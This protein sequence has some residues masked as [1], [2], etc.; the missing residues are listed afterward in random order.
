MSK[1]GRNKKNAQQNRLDDLTR[2]QKIKN[3]L[4]QNN[5]KLFWLIVGLA[6]IIRL[7]YLFQLYRHNPTVNSFIH[8]SAYF[9]HLAQQVVSDGMIL[10]RSFYLS[11][12]YIYFLAL[13]YSIGIHNLLV[14]RLLQTVLGALGCGL[15]FLIGKRFFLPAVALGGALIQIFYGPIL[16]FEGNLLA[17]SLVLFL[18][19]LS[20]YLIMLYHQDHKKWAGI[21]SGFTLA[22]A[23]IG[24]PNL[25]LVLPVP[26]IYLILNQSAPISFGRRL[27]PI[28]NWAIGFIIPFILTTT[29][30]YLADKSYIPLT[31]HGG[32]NFY[33]GNHEQASGQWEAPEGME[34]SVSAINL[35]QAQQVAEKETGKELTPV[36]VSNF[37]YQKAWHFIV[38]KPGAWLGLMLKKTFLFWSGYEIPLNFD[39]YFHQQFS[40][41]LKIPFTQ[42]YLLFPLALLG[43]IYGLRDWKKFWP[44]YGLILLYAFSVILFFI[45]GRYRLIIIPFILLFSAYGIYWLYER[46]QKKNYKPLIYVTATLIILMALNTVFVLSKTK[47]SNFGNDYYNIALAKLY[48]ED[49]QQAV[50]WGQ[51]AAKAAPENPN[52]HYNL[53]IAYLKQKEYE[54]AIAAFKKTVALNPEDASALRNLGGLL[55]M[56]GQVQESIPILEQAIQLDATAVNAYLN[57]GK[58]YFDRQQY[59]RAKQQWEKVLSIDP[60]NSTAQSNIRV[61]KRLLNE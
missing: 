9:N 45:S 39:Y 8:D 23:V 5:Q 11:P 26:L 59:H 30:N 25:L 13:F 10:D 53:G 27:R 54:Q 47:Q 34:S 44:L 15:T 19:L 46:F 32:I 17:T 55:L 49:Y 22:L 52:I 38:T 21:L 28:L 40:F 31:S 36:E 14:I 6:F 58:A 48:E 33:I 7:L 35:E 57:L 50:H 41:L 12:L 16:F 2:W 4:F 24:R 29:H 43:M 37:W 1:P 51:L 18:T 3:L 56:Q 61:V 60:D 20:F 42:F